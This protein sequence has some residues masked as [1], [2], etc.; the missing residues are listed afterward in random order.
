MQKYGELLRMLLEKRG[1]TNTE[2]ADI[3]LNPNYERDFYD[4]FLMRDM[5]KS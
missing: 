1:I 3:F 4:P 5:E 2:D